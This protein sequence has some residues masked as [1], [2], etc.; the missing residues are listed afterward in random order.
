[1][2]EQQPLVY[3]QG[4]RDS[5]LEHCSEDQFVT[6]CL[7]SNSVTLHSALIKFC[8]KIL[9]DTSKDL[10]KG[11]TI[12]DIPQLKSSFG[13]RKK[14]VG[15]ANWCRYEIDSHLGL[16]PTDTRTIIPLPWQTMEEDTVFMHAENI[17]IQLKPEFWD[18]FSDGL[19]HTIYISDDDTFL[20]RDF[21]NVTDYPRSS[22]SDFV[23]IT[24]P[25]GLYP[26]F[27]MRSLNDTL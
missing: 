18:G 8:N 26:K 6:K 3:S 13:V 1:M 19:L 7:E 14:V 20:V 4:L 22:V 27:H 16:Y 9:S 10:Y 17:L 5:I 2:N 23:R 25:P 24:R 12:D 15:L 11:V 21:D